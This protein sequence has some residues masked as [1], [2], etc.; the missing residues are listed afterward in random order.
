VNK[1]SNIF[2]GR[3]WYSDN[4]ANRVASYDLHLLINDT[5]PI[6][7][8]N[9]P[10]GDEIALIKKSTFDLHC[11]ISSTQSVLWKHDCLR[12]TRTAQVQCT[13]AW[14]RQ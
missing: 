12:F 4:Y 13:V 2:Y 1:V 14:Y 5:K 7:L 8:T 11:W 3:A 6:K 10:F 9:R